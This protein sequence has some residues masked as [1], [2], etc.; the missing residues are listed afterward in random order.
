MEAP[1]LLW[2]FIS[3]IV[4]VIRSYITGGR[5]FSAQ[6]GSA[7]PRRWVL[8]LLKKVNLLFVV[9]SNYTDFSSDLQVLYQVTTDIYQVTLTFTE[10]Y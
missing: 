6:S 3:T 1:R 7:V 10:L 5:E 8:D 9:E 4:T 2:T